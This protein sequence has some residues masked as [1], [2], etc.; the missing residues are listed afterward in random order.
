MVL[1]AKTPWIKG[2]G[3]LKNKVLGHA[4]L[5]PPPIPVFPQLDINK[6]LAFC[7]FPLLPFGMMFKNML[8]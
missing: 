6:N 2:E 3:T 7:Q 1:V 5:E 8:F 4:S